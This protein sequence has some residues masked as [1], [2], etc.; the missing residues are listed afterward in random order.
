MNRRLALM[1]GLGVLASARIGVAQDLV[2]GY[3]GLP[4]KAS[5]ESATGINVAEGMLLH[6]GAGAEAGY[7]SNVFYGS[8]QSATVGSGIIRTTGYAELTNSSRTGGA[9]SGLSFD[10]RGGLTYR[11]YTSDNPGVVKYR[12]A[13]QP[14][15]GLSLGY[16]AGR[17]S[18]QLTDPFNR[19]Q[20]PPHRHT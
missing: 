19:T 16:G 13:F 5:G 17:L 3:Q 10:L 15:A 11:R 6:V 18:F 9:P 4:Q 1:V 20:D 7:D 12:D 14:V 2:I 8:P